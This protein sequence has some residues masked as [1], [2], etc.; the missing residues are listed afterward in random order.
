MICG[1]TS[2]GFRYKIEDEVLD[3][4]ELLEV[5]VE[6]SN[7]NLA[8]VPRM[9]NLLLGTEQ[10]K[11]LKNHIKEQQGR[12]TTSGIVNEIMEI[13]QSSKVKNS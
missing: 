12:V 8:C 5:L 7:D 11:D 6:V 1:K 4:Y 10:A 9:V 13:F 2:S 3:D